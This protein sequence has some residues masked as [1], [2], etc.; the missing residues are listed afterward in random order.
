MALLSLTPF[1]EISTPDL[2]AMAQVMP[3]GTK[4]QIPDRLTAI[5]LIL[6][7]PACGH[8][9]GQN[10]PADYIRR[11]NAPLS[12]A[13]G[14]VLSDRASIL[15]HRVRPNH[16]ALLRDRDIHFSDDLAIVV[17]DVHRIL[18]SFLDLRLRYGG[19][20]GTAT[21]R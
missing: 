20:S 8:G 10:L 17:A 7:F 12:V 3:G 2:I 21:G 4:V 18:F 15:V 13:D 9:L 5:V 1:R 11:A 14:N 6:G 16:G 19:I